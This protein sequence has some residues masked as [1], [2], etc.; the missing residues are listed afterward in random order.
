L[1]PTDCTYL[2]KNNELKLISSVLILIYTWALETA[3][4]L[5]SAG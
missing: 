5:N 3:R 2:N 4:E 1:C